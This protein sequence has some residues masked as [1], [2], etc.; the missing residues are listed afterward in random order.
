MKHP[1][2]KIDSPR[3]KAKITPSAKPKKTQ[4]ESRPHSE[5]VN[6]LQA[7]K[8]EL[9]KQID[10]LRK[11]QARLEEINSKYLDLYQS[12]PVGYFIF[13]KK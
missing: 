1:I 4:K 10:E 8:I 11:S 9:E 12:A 2:K 6:D 5:I 3:V 13:D 7:N